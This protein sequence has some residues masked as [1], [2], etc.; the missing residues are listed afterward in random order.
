MTIR[1]KR[2]PTITMMTSLPIHLSNHRPQSHKGLE[3]NLLSR[4]NHQRKKRKRPAK[5]KPEPKKLPWEKR[6]K[7]TK[8]TVDEEVKER[9]NRKS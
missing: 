7:E 6:D 2:A 1:E 3:R 9:K 8:T 4:C 5:K